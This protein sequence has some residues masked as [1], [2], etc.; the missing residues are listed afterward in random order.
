M[1]NLF[2][3]ANNG[4]FLRP[5]ILPS[6]LCTQSCSC[7][8]IEKQG[9]ASLVACPNTYTSN[10][11][12]NNKKKIRDNNMLNYNHDYNTT[13]AAVVNSSIILSLVLIQQLHE[14]VPN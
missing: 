3:F 4:E 10:K 9:M 8:I 11:S 12:T 7:W 5:Y 6:M 13:S 1:K 2:G 14:S